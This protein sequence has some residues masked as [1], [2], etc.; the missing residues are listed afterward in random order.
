MGNLEFKNELDKV[1]R[2]AIIL[3]FLFVSIVLLIGCKSP[4]VDCKKKQKEI[5]AFLDST[6]Y[7]K[8][9]VDVHYSKGDKKGIVVYLT[10]KGGIH[11][12]VYEN[13]AKENIASFLVYKFFRNEKISNDEY[14][15]IQYSH[16]QSHQMDNW[17]EY[18]NNLRELIFL[19]F[20]NNPCFYKQ[21]EYMISTLDPEDYFTL[22][23]FMNWTDNE[24]INVKPSYKPNKLNFFKTLYA[25]SKYT[26]TTV[27]SAKKI[28]NMEVL[29]ILM[30]QKAIRDNNEPIL[31]KQLNKVYNIGKINTEYQLA[32]LLMFFILKDS[33]GAIEPQNSEHIINH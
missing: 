1:N 30:L 5:Q 22:D 27:D 9:S 6:I 21:M 29:R 2:S 11:E 26:C 18:N 23:Y 4:R 13:I 19:S 33:L 10:G 31:V 28:D 32:D 25:A 3:T 17:F 16:Y 20:Y 7:L 8:L 15:V 12:E 24:L 14:L